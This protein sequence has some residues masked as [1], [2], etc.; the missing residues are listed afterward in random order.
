MSEI[1]LRGVLVVAAFVVEIIAKVQEAIF[2][3][4]SAFGII[5]LY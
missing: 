2:T 1:G 4:P 3:F 5:R